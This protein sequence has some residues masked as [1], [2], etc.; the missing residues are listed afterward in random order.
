MSSPWTQRETAAG[1][2]SR[3]RDMISPRPWATPRVSVLA[4]APAF[5]FL[6]RA[7]AVLVPDVSLYL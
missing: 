5:D 1:P 3:F 2:I 6:S 7:S 4:S